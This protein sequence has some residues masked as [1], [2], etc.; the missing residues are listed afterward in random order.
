MRSSHEALKERSEISSA[1]SSWMMES[2]SFDVRFED[3]GATEFSSH[4]YELVPMVELA[5]IDDPELEI[6]E[7]DRLL[8]NM[9]GASADAKLG[10]ELLSGKIRRGESTV[11]MQEEAWAW[12]T[13]PAAVLPLFESEGADSSGTEV[14]SLG[15]S[16]SRENE[17]LGDGEGPDSQLAEDSD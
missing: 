7:F 17:S 15:R 4:E 10:W 8:A 2:S 9:C 5:S 1:L 12:L 11:F 3:P 16:S 13:K 14:A 6:P